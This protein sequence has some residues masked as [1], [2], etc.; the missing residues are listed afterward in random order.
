VKVE[1]V[2]E[3]MKGKKRELCPNTSGWKPRFRE[4]AE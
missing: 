3:E 4:V 1:A 2:L